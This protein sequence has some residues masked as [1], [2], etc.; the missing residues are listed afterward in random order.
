[1]R[2]PPPQRSVSPHIPSASKPFLRTY[3]L[4]ASYI[5]VGLR[6]RMVDL[7]S[8]VADRFPKG[9]LNVFDRDLRYMFASGEGL[10][11]VGL[12]PDHLIGRTVYELFPDVATLV[13]PFYRRAFEG[14][15]V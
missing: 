3:C 8:A 6:A 12:Y 9:S 10:A 15:S 14:E 4:A 5:T 7:L 1:M 2:P 11:A 13:Q